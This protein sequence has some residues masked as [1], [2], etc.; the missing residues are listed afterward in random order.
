MIRHNETLI[1]YCHDEMMRSGDLTLATEEL[2][3]KLLK[4]FC[5]TIPKQYIII[6]GLDE[7]P[8]ATR[9]TSLKILT[10]VIKTCDQTL[11]FGKPRLLIVSQKLGDIEKS[12][13]DANSM[14][15]R[16]EDNQKD[17][18]EFVHTRAGELN[19]KFDLETELVDRIEDAT[20]EYTHGLNLFGLSSCYDR[21]CVLT[22]NIS[23]GMFLF[24][25]LVMENLQM[26]TNRKQCEEEMETA[27]FPKRIEDA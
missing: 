10:S 22:F 11:H 20:L 13:A 9:Q 16:R 3:K 17:I 7:C 15:I 2:A 8:P 4:V 26:C 19:Q 27:V 24:A 5:E 21:G 25:V 14:G 6:D 1:P 18:M 23:I 12:L